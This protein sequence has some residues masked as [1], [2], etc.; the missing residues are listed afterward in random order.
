MVTGTTGCITG[1]YTWV[2]SKPRVK[3][4]LDE[5]AVAPIRAYD[6]DAGLDLRSPVDFMVPAHGSYTV[7]TGVHVEIPKNHVG[8]LKSKSGL[9]VKKNITS[10]G[11]IDSGYIGSIVVKLYNHGNEDYEVKRGDKITQLV[12]C[13]VMIP[14]LVLVGA[15]DETDRGTNGFGSSGR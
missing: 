13:P 6:A 8:F 9:N 15:L 1:E 2:S 11:T 4:V 14:D 5:C 3:I 7:D 10:E 12:I